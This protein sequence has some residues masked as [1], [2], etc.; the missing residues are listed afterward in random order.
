MD[1][2]SYEGSIFA[3]F[4]YQ[5]REYYMEPFGTFWGAKMLGDLTI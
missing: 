3:Y 4:I 1:P 5:N 2:I